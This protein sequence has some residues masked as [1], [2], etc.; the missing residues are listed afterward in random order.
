MTIRGTDGQEFEALF[1][2][3]EDIEARRTGSGQFFSASDAARRAELER[4][5]LELVSSDMPA[6]SVAAGCG[7]RVISGSRS[8]RCR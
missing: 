1:A 3:L 7:C 8:G 6:C 4:R 5:L 2:E